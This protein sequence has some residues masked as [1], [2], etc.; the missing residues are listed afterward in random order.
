[1]VDHTQIE[2]NFVVKYS[3]DHKYNQNISNNCK[4]F[5]I[6]IILLFF[7][8]LVFFCFASMKEFLIFFLIKNY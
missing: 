2:Q 3:S 1:M 5:F 4:Q 6:K 8:E 7:G